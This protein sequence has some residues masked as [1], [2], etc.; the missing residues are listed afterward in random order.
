MTE[1]RYWLKSWKEALAIF[2]DALSFKPNRKASFKKQALSALFGFA[3]L[4]ATSFFM[5]WLGDRINAPGMAVTRFLARVQAPLTAELSYPEKARGQISVVMYDRQFLEA[6]GA[7]WPI[8]YQE[9]A[10]WIGRLVE[11]PGAKP[12]ALMIDITFG[13]ERNDPTI[14]ALKAKLCEIGRV[15]RIPVYLAALADPR[16]GGLRVRDGL[17]Q[18]T[19]ED[20]CFTLVGVDYVPDPLDGLAWSYQLNRFF[21]GAGWLPG[22]PP[23]GSPAPQYRSAALAMAQDVGGV[24][25]DNR[26]E[27]MALMWGFKAETQDDRPNLTRDC[28][29]GEHDLQRW[30]PKLIRQ[31]WERDDKPPLCPYHRSISFAQVAEMEEAALGEFV[32]NKFV[33]IGAQVPGYNDHA[34]SPVHG[35][36]PGVYMHAMALDN[37]LSYG[38]DY[39]ISAEWTLPPHPDLVLPGLVSV[40]IVFAVSLGW[41]TASRRGRENDE[42]V[43]PRE[44]KSGF[45]KRVRESLGIAAIWVLRICAQSVIAIVLISAL[46]YVFRIGML[47]VVELVGMTLVAEGLGYMSRIQWL[48]SGPQENQL[49]QRKKETKPCER[50]SAS[51]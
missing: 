24:K 49:C 35:L 33:F 11:L 22:Q 1:A 6:Q 44:L 2:S 15:H 9:H 10:D 23:P 7:A 12:R 28:D 37:F 13:Q 43:C 30:I 8:S 45:A 21:D 38:D 50:K 4:A 5:L 14:D 46:Q 51:A 25:L 48:I 26:P 32:G 34:N 39:K 3:L 19:G 31:I 27:P 20:A 16:D 18:G 41:H 29:P 17:A 36:I 40:A 42:F 47:P